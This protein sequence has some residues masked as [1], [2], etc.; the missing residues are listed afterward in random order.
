MRRRLLKLLYKSMDSALSPPGNAE[1]EAALGESEELRRDR[2]A[3]LAIRRAAAD[4]APRGFAPGFAD[5]VVA[6]AK[7]RIRKPEGIDA[8]FEALKTVFK[9]VAV[10]TAVLLV[11]LVAYSVSRGD[12][13]PKSEI[14]YASDITMNK[15][16]ELTSF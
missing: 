15:V 8:V 9:P 13:I 2:S 1:L 6:A 10:A 16:L 3:I 7:T 4:T 12:L 14:Y 5:R 11:V